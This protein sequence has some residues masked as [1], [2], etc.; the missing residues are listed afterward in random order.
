MT[1]ATKLGDEQESW[2]QTLVTMTPDENA[3]IRAMSETA[4]ISSVGEDPGLLGVSE[5]VDRRTLRA[6][7]T[8]ES[9]IDVREL[10]ERISY[11]D[12]E[13][14]TSLRGVFKVELHT[15]GKNEATQTTYSGI[16]I[17]FRDI[18]EVMSG[19][20]GMP[21]S[22]KST[23]VTQTII[24][25][26][27]QTSTS[28]VVAQLAD[29]ISREDLQRID[30]T[31]EPTAASS[32]A[33]DQLYYIL[34][35]VFWLSEP[36]YQMPK[37]KLKDMES[38]TYIK[39]NTDSGKVTLDTD[40]QTY[41]SCE[42]TASNTEL[43]TEWSA[44]KSFTQSIIDTCLEIGVYSRIVAESTL[45]EVVERCLNQIHLPYKNE[46]VQTLAPCKPLEDKDDE[47]LRK[48]RLEIVVDTL[49]S[50]IV[51]LPV[52]RIIL[53]IA[54]LEICKDAPNVADS[55]LNRIQRSAVIRAERLEAIRQEKLTFHKPMDDIF[56]ARRKRLSELLKNN[57]TRVT[58][59]SAGTQTGLAGVTNIAKIKE[60]RETICSICTRHS[61][62]TD[63]DANLLDQGEYRP[64]KNVP[65]KILRTQDIL[66]TYNPCYVVATPSE[67]RMRQFPATPVRRNR[68]HLLPSSRPATPL[69]RASSPPA[70]FDS[71]SS[72]VKFERHSDFISPRCTRSRSCA[73]AAG[74]LDDWS[75]VVEDTSSIGHAWSV[76]GSSIAENKSIGS[77]LSGV[78]FSRSSGNPNGRDCGRSC[79]DLPLSGAKAL[80]ILKEVFNRSEGSCSDFDPDDKDI[81]RSTD[82]NAV[83]EPDSHL[84]PN[85][86]SFGEGVRVIPIIHLPNQRKQQ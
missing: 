1:G 18:A 43:L 75:K 42:P 62:C 40:T 44:L 28:H 36:G 49:E 33:V 32:C 14:Q 83:N 13:C 22:E 20:Q 79:R 69:T 80:R 66:M 45:D 23:R 24:I 71:N 21:T 52:L 2:A 72:C 7:I 31:L 82:V 57:A 86:K 9:L 55:I 16:K 84:I 25:F 4:V 64:D 17:P 65:T 68:S 30:N 8:R 41:L 35:R 73:Q 34:E 15:D 11:N 81:P 29:V 63:C 3:T 85:G 47:I 70:S 50:T 76:P 48:L 26:D 53:E 54:C 60:P 38:Q 74:S 51:V 27:S 67:I 46:A 78:S 6:T 12:A 39:C 77:S 56:D 10:D 19:L 59:S 61:E 37:P 5:I 58:R